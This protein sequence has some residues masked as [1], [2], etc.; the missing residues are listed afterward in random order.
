MPVPEQTRRLEARATPSHPQAGS[1]RY[2]KSPAGWKPAL[3]QV[4]R[5]LEARV[6][7]SWGRKTGILP[8][9]EQAPAGW[10][11]CATSTIIIIA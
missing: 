7:P 5:R 6:T 3:R 4:T 8:V 2:A 9:P 10:R 11:A 1:P